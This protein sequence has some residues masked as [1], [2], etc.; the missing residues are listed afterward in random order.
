MELIAARGEVE[1]QVMAKICKIVDGFK[2]P[3]EW[4]LC[5]VVPI[6]KGKCDIRNCSCNRA[7]KLLD[8]GMKVVEMVQEKRQSKIDNANEMQFVFTPERRTMDAVFILRRLQE[9]HHAMGR[10]LYVLFVDLEKAFTEHQVKCW[11][12]K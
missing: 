1:I 10:K 9:V 11:N 12:G 3:V 4:V 5:T 2:M 6:F 8:H 7:G